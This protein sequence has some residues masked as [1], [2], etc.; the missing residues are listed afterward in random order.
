MFQGKLVYNTRQKLNLTQAQLADGT[1]TQ[2]T[3]SKLE[4]HNIAPT[5][6]ILVRICER[7]G[8]TLNDLFTE[9]SQDQIGRAHV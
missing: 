4:N 3:I 8:L 2:N 6:A 1:C 9:F 5:A 7:L